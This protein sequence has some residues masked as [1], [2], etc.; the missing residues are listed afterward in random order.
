[1]N[2]AEADRRQSLEDRVLALFRSRP[3]RWIA[4]TELA[5]AGGACAWRTRI[6][7]A[8]KV[9]R[10]EGGS[11]EWNK[12]VHASAYRYVPYVPLGRDASEYVVQP[13]LF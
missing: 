5:E 10:K 6:S 3:L 8:R 2:R 11:V 7:D 13:G 9:F 4:W 1:M 12:R